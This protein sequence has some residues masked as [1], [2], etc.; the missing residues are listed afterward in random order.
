MEPAKFDELTKVLATST[1][2][3]Q[4]LRRIGGILG[5]TAL[6][7]L[8]PG[9]A[10]ASNSACAHFC[11]A[12]FGAETEAAGKCIRDAAHGTGLCHQC[13]S[14]AP[15]SICCTRNSSGFCSSYSGAQCPCP[16]GQTCQN[17]TCVT[18]CTA[19]GGTCSG[20][21]DCCAG[22]CSNGVCC[23][24]GQVGLSN[25]SCVTPCSSLGQDTCSGPCGTG[26]CSP[27]AS[28]AIYCLTSTVPSNGA[29]ISDRDCPKGYFC[30]FA[31]AGTTQ[32]CFGLC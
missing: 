6:A 26:F 23:A 19:N 4:A 12:V 31:P 21:T 18:P 28:G 20:N 14:A 29:C 22:N 9:L 2:R 13:G 3:R 17:G 1:S 25:G 8:F 24:S 15:S 7:G 27:D 30:Y 5:G 11:N 10:F 16:S 32:F